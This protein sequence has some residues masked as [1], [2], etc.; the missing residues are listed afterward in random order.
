MS[1][2][3]LGRIHPSW[4]LVLWGIGVIVGAVFEIL[5]KFTGFLSGT[6]LVV[7]LVGLIISISINYRIVGLIAFISGVI[8]AGNR[9]APGFIGMEQLRGFYGNEVEVSGRIVNDLDVSE[10]KITLVLEVERIQVENK[11]PPEIRGAPEI[12]VALSTKLD[13]AE[14]PRR[15]DRITVRGVVNEG[16][17]NYAGNMFRPEIIKVIR[18]SPG[19]FFLEVRDGFAERIREYLNEPEAGLALG[20]LLGVK[21]EVDEKFLATLQVVGLT[22]I[23]VASGTQLS[24]L[25]EIAKKVFGKVSRFAGMAG[26]ALLIICFTGMV[27]LSPSML[28]A[29]IVAGMSLIA[30]HFG[31]EQETWRMLLLVMA[32]TLIYEPRN[33]SDLG[34][35][36]S[37][38]S[39]FGLLVVGPKLTKFF[40]GEREPGFIGE[41]V[42]SS[43]AAGIAVTPILLYNFGSIS[44]ISILMNLLILPTISPVMGLTFMM[45]VGAMLVGN[46][47]PVVGIVAEL[48]KVILDYH[49]NTINSLG[50]F[51]FFLIEIPKNNLAVM[52]I[53]VPILLLLIPYKKI[54]RRK[55]NLS[56]D[57]LVFVE[58]NIEISTGDTDQ[59]NS[60]SNIIKE[61]DNVI[62]ERV[63]SEEVGENGG[64]KG[65]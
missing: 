18:P 41:T 23:I 28:R 39:F 34:W 64:D 29:G 45:G 16:F 7:S 47:N 38:G 33:L 55:N 60:S 21:A 6:W 59:D 53:Y 63:E 13:T 31:R 15:S 10:S 44:L 17:G 37:F 8:L 26:A 57:E 4:M 32:G 27:G 43:L 12:Y 22:H 2:K 1:K 20:Y 54:F 61:T 58:E 9:A 42:F 49:I 56:P 24:I 19:D 30:W 40:F 14:M 50:G 62:R 5:T 35:Q 51:R 3:L 11:A 36:L 48:T 25:A 46:D 65:G 52:L